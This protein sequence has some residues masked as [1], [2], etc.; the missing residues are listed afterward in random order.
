MFTRT[1]VIPATNGRR[2]LDYG[3]E[4]EPFDTEVQSVAAVHADY[5]DGG[6]PFLID[7]TLAPEATEVTIRV[8][9]R[10]WIIGPWRLIAADLGWGMIP[11]TAR[12]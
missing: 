7:G 1:Y 8:R 9:R 12:G 5:G 11:R 3:G 10:W 6:T 2:Y 4:E